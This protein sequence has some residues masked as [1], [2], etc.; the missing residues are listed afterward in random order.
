MSSLG[1]KQKKCR[2]E[3][4]LISSVYI[5][6]RFVN[7]SIKFKKLVDIRVVPINYQVAHHS[8]KNGHIR[9][10]LGLLV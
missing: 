7:N 9:I 6:V 10:N 8:G 3:K 2:L 1:L 5:L 4:Y